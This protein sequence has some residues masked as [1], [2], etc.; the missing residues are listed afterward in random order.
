[1]HE[2]TGDSVHGLI[3]A[4][5]TMCNEAVFDRSLVIVKD[6]LILEFSDA[7]LVEILELRLKG[8]KDGC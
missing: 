1:M 8:L 5:I 2:L 7:Q 3:V 4:A 6:G